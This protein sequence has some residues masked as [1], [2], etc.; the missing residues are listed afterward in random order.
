MRIERE[1]KAATPSSTKRTGQGSI[2]NLD[3]WQA[4]YEHTGELPS[5][6]TLRAAVINA[7]VERDNTNKP[8]WH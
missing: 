5:D 1:M 6:F 4:K 7:R 8:A 3:Y 2:D